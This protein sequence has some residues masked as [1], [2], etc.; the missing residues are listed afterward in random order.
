[1][2]VTA[3]PDLK[4]P[5]KAAKFWEQAKSYGATV[6]F[7]P[8]EMAQVS[9]ARVLM[10]LKDAAAWRSFQERQ[11]KLK[12]KEKAAA[13]MPPPASAPERRPGP[14]ERERTAVRGQLDRLRKTGSAKD[15]E[16][17]LSKFD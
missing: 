14:A 7:T 17:F 1:M 4:D 5:A 3:M 8:Q 2:L 12:E 16:A 10:V 15:A 11:A 13:P 9:D 6:G